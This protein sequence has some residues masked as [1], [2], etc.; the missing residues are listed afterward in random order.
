M[1]QSIG[2]HEDLRKHILSEYPTPI[3]RLTKRIF[4]RKTKNYCQEILHGYNYIWTFMGHLILADYFRLGVP[5]PR[6]N[7]L[8]ISTVRS[9][10]THRWIEVFRGLLN[11][12]GEKTSI[13][14]LMSLYRSCISADESLQERLE[15]LTKRTQMSYIPFDDREAAGYEVNL[16]KL[17]ENIGFLAEYS[18]IMKREDGIFLLKGEDGPVKLKKEVDIKVNDVIL[19]GKGGK[20]ILTLSP[21][22]VPSTN[23]DGVRFF[24]FRKDQ[25]SYKSFVRTPGIARV[26]KEY[27][28]ILAGKPDFTK[29]EE[30]LPEDPPFPEMKN[31]IG[32][33]LSDPNCQR[34]LIEGPPGSGKTMLIANLDRFIDIGKFN[35]IKYYLADYSILTST[36]IFTRFLYIHL[37]NL[38]GKPHK[39]DFKGVGWH[40]FK[41][42]VLSSFAK[43]GKKAILAIDSIDIAEKP[44][45]GE[46]VSIDEYIQMDLPKNL[47]ILFTTRTGDYPLRFDTRITM[48]GIDINFAMKLAGKT[49][50][51]GEQIR[52]KVNL[53]GGN[54]GY[55]FRAMDGSKSADS[56]LPPYIKRCFV[57]LLF[58]YNIFHPVREQ[59]CRYLAEAEKPPTL[60]QVAAD[61][62][63]YAPVIL[64]HFR[65]MLPLIKTEPE[66]S[67]IR[68]RLFIPAFADYVRSL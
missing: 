6:H 58:R 43:S 39:P 15:K 33:A 66:R 30:N 34:I 57:D 63:I 23:P 32:K 65:E 64:K 2:I 17:L 25:E 50:F 40:Q 44:L 28:N 49:G 7:I 13:P 46:R 1:S 52:E 5:S 36:T 68:Y 3:A 16:F 59:V 21:F 26:V 29:T 18:I 4:D 60:Q 27:Q 11:V 9:M 61:L 22:I 48:P 62:E 53:Y 8:L 42:K 20:K 35:I 55:I 38:L 51:D 31:K 12:I 19:C 54:A 10:N 41:K 45:P 67:V 56:N 24:D 47:Y 37:N 14:E